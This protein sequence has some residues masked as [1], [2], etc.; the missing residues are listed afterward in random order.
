M[1]VLEVAMS[2][3]RFVQTLLG[4]IHVPVTLAIV[5]QVIDELVLVSGYHN[6]IITMIVVTLNVVTDSL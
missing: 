2:V 6:N 4:V 5:W 3:L 1:N